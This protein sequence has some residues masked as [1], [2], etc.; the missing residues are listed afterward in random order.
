MNH[1]K[2]AALRK[3]SGGKRPDFLT[4]LKGIYG[5]KK[6]RVNGAQ[7]LEKERAGPKG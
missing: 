6:L 5:S 7:L 2:R 3:A 1:M 4:R